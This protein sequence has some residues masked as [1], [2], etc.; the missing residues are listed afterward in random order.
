MRNATR[1]EVLYLSGGA[2]ALGLSGSLSFIPSAI[3][4]EIR[5][6]GYHNYA[7]GDIDVTA[8]Y[9]GIWE[10]SHDDGFIRNATVD[11]ARA[12]LEEGGHST[13]FIPIEFTQTV[14][15]SGDEV[16]LID[17]G[18]GGQ[19]SPKAGAMMDNMKAAG[20][21][22]ASVNKILVSHFHPDHVFGLMEKETNA[23]IF[24]NVEII[25]PETE[26]AFWSDPAT[27]EKMPDS[28]KPLVQRLQATLAKWDNVTRVDGER[29]VAP[30]ISML[31]AYGHTPGHTA[32]LVGSGSDELIVMGDISN[33]PA[34]FVA[35][36][37]WHAVFDM[38]PELAEQ[39]R[40]AMFDRA[41]AD[42][43]TVAGYHFGLPNA[44][45]IEKDG[46]GYAFVPLS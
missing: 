12:A 39:N 3:A 17:A 24:P 23:Q 36:P 2:A 16:I 18:T 35:N 25:V 19:L 42:G 30:G 40:R 31:P 32:Y 44:G 10:K 38:N 11:D 29:E 21:D 13:D 22:P 45:K 27:L 7:I 15:R 34:L 8:I 43:A 46:D 9:D 37:G 28:A 41:V 1:R 14:I 6:K 4:D 5:E 20:I 33:I 26:Y